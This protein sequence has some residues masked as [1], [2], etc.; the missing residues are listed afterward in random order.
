[1]AWR[2][3]RVINGL[4]RDA[5]R[6]EVLEG[7]HRAGPIAVYAGLLAYA[8]ARNY[9]TGWAYYAFKE[10]FGAGPRPQDRRVKPQALPNFLIEEWAAGRKRS[11][12]RLPL[13]QRH[14]GRAIDRGRA[15]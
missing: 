12:P 4:V 14:V 9:R 3:E 6:D 5:R 2:G 11:R 8:L 15:F 13:F 7:L 1:M 10:I